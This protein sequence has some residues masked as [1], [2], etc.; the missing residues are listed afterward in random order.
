[1]QI[2]VY[3]H[4]CILLKNTCVIGALLRGTSIQY[5]SRH[6]KYLMPQIKISAKNAMSL[7]KSWSKASESLSKYQS[8]IL[9]YPRVIIMIS[10]G[11]SLHVI[12]CFATKIQKTIQLKSSKQELVDF[13]GD[14]SA[15]WRRQRQN[16]YANGKWPKIDSRANKAVCEYVHIPIY[17]MVLAIFR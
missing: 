9:H 10:L 5:A 1:M 6:T 2:Y 7:L 11:I 12:P 17:M 4:M 8:R 13:A 3:M 14:I 15:R 16:R